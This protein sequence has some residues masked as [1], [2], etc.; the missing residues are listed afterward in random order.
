MLFSR[1][2]MICRMG[3][4]EPGQFIVQTLDACLS[5]RI[6]YQPK[7]KLGARQAKGN[8]AG[9]G[10]EWSRVSICKHEIHIPSAYSLLS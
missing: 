1:V 6:F 9:L 10:Y 8:D 2:A 3:L 5:C 4:T 7:T